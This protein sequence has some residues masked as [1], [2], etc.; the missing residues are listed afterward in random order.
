MAV[1]RLQYGQEFEKRKKKQSFE[2]AF[3][4]AYE[5][6]SVKKPKKKPKKKVLKYVPGLA[7][8]KLPPDL[9]EGQKERWRRIR[10]WRRRKQKGN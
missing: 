8:D 4:G 10:R 3:W 9:T 7:K 1:R 2:E 6:S 5:K